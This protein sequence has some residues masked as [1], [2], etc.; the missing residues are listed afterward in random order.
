[1]RLLFRDY[2]RLG[3]AVVIPL[4]IFPHKV[5]RCTGEGFMYC[6]VRFAR[7]QLMLPI[8]SQ[9]LMPKALL[10]CTHHAHTHVTAH[11]EFWNWHVRLLPHSPVAVPSSHS[12]IG[13]QFHSHQICWYM[14]NVYKLW[15]SAKRARQGM[16]GIALRR[17]HP[18]SKRS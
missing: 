3:R 5:F 9:S 1:M 6:H 8:H 14:S 7:R 2:L 16:A 11:R 4:G 17:A 13:L 15:L 10:S 18:V 12:I